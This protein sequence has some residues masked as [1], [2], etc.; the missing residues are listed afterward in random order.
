MFHLSTSIR[1]RQP[2]PTMTLP[3]LCSAIRSQLY[4][5]QISAWCD[6]IKKS[7][8]TIYDTGRLIFSTRTTTS[9]AGD[10]ATPTSPSTFVGAT[11][12]SSLASSPNASSTH[13][14][15]GGVVS[16]GVCVSGNV[17]GNVGCAKRRP[18]RLNIF[19]RI[20]QY[21]DNK[22]PACFNSKPNVHNFPNVN[23]SENYSVSVCLKSL[24]RI[25]G[26]I[27]KVGT[28]SATAA[29]AVET[30][31]ATKTTPVTATIGTS[32]TMTT[33][34]KAASTPVC[35]RMAAKAAAAAAMSAVPTTVANKPTTT[36]KILT[37][38]CDNNKYSKEHHQQQ[39]QQPKTAVFN[40]NHEVMNH[41]N[42]SCHDKH[43]DDHD[44]GDGDGDDHDEADHD[45]DV[46]CDS[47]MCSAGVDEGC[48]GVE[49]LCGGDG[50]S[51][52][53]SFSTN[54]GT[55]SHREK[56]LLKYRK[57]MLKRDKKQR[58]IVT[59]ECGNNPQTLEEG[60]KMDQGEDEEADAD[61]DNDDEE[62]EN[63]EPDQVSENDVN[64]T[65]KC[66]RQQQQLPNSF[67]NNSIPSTNHEQQSRQPEEPQQHHVKM[68]ST[69]T[70]TTTN[71]CASCG[72]EK[73]MICLKCNPL[74]NPMSGTKTAANGSGFNCYD[75]DDG[76]DAES[77]SISSSASTS[78]C[79]LSSSD[80]IHTPR[81]KAELLL[82]AIQ[83]TPK[84]NK[85]HKKAKDLQQHI[86]AI[87]QA[88]TTPTA[89]HPQQQQ[90]HSS[91]NNNQLARSI[92]S[93][94]NSVTITTS[95]TSSSLNGTMQAQGCQVCKRQKTQHTFQPNTRQLD[96]VSL[97]DTSSILAAATSTS[98]SVR[99]SQ[100]NGK[101]SD[102]IVNES[103]NE[104]DGKKM[105]A[106]ED[107]VD[108]ALVADIGKELSPL[109]DV[110][111]CADV[112]GFN[113]HEIMEEVSNLF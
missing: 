18:P 20:K 63:R 21:D 111:L 39:K 3:S 92:P 59:N 41:G 14:P 93:S 69:G 13:S 9:P 42:H 98:Q 78:A 99:L 100:T 38:I 67:I 49:S 106:A 84:A 97:K 4:F 10:L 77:T 40:A 44:Y 55:I 29:G 88:I 46:E 1:F 75:N 51:S 45:F 82:Q 107:C 16:V 70:Q 65:T 56:Q 71:T 68:I 79:S 58:K 87:K 89:H 52:N 73:S 33:T 109:L 104:A 108:N 2:P 95:T 72:F 60:H 50:D 37:M 8:K 61:A 5:S 64:S 36:A 76:M 24:P 35:A 83:R 90:H 80:I 85:K 62:E 105:S 113:N 43:N 6:L 19:Y 31:T 57:R 48:V 96:D 17:I 81:N 91:N 53:S 25:T 11:S 112:D 32:T 23:I 28:A 103:E 86:T 94:S 102:T 34:P 47:K 30:P 27:P 101:K 15:S 26:G 22:T 110:K 12:P 66:Q 74:R 54:Y 7:D